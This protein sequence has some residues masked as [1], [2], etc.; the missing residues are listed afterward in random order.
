MPFF[1]DCYVIFFPFYVTLGEG[2]EACF[3]GMPNLALLGTTTIRLT[4]KRDLCG[5]SLDIELGEWPGAGG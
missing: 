4:L 1:S 3:I 5:G 2:G